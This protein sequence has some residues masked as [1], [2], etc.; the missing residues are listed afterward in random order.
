M[1]FDILH[2][3]NV[4]VEMFYYFRERFNVYREMK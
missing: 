2:I 1:L 3:Y 4:Y